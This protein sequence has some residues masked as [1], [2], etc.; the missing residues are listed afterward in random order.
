MR[1]TLGPQI[2]LTALKVIMTQQIATSRI[3]FFDGFTPL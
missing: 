1:I 2:E 3:F